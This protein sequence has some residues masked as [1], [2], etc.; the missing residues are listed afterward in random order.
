MA[1]TDLI[2]SVINGVTQR[3]EMVTYYRDKVNA[4]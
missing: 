3:K 1:F 2:P 4:H